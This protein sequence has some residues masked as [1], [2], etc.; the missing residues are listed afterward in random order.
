MEAMGVNN[1]FDKVEIIDCS[2][3]EYF[4]IDAYS[5]SDIRRLLK[6]HMNPWGVKKQRETPISESD[7]M[8]IGSVVDC[9]ITEPHLVDTRYQREPEFDFYPTTIAQEGFAHMLSQGVPLMDAYAANYKAATEAKAKKLQEQLDP[10]MA[11]Q[12]SIA[13]SGKTS[14]R[15]DLWERAQCGIQAARKHKLFPGVVKDSETQKVF[16]GEAFGVR[17]KGMADLINPHVVTDVKTTEDWLKIRSN[18]FRR[19]YNVQGRLYTWLAKMDAMQHFY[20]ETVEPYRTKMVD[21]TDHIIE[22]SA[23]TR[24]LM[25]RLAHAHNTG[26]WKHSMEYD[27]HQ[28]YEEL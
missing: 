10:W 15:S 9:S 8:L 27:T 6:D 11:Y 4:P 14:V 22:A 1:P 26:N 23:L 5:S 28:G 7:Q 12:R 19:G 17:W 16:I 20:I 18:F 24:E 25:M 3:E 2:Q 21:T 13:D